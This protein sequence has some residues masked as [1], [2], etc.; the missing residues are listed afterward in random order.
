MDKILLEIKD[1]LKHDS[2]FVDINWPKDISENS[3]K[4]FIWVGT[5]DGKIGNWGCHYEFIFGKDRK[6]HTE[7]HLSETGCQSLFMNIDLGSYLILKN[8]RRPK[9]EKLF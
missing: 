6:L 5:K 4:G 1:Y 8:G 3:H 7:V 9:T 2:V